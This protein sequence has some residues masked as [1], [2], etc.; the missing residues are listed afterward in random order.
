[1]TT[2]QQVFWDNYTFFAG[3]GDDK[4]FLD[5]IPFRNHISN[6]LNVGKSHRGRSYRMIHWVFT[7]NG[8]K[9]LDSIK[10]KHQ[11]RWDQHCTLFSFYC[12]LMHTG[13]FDL[14]KLKKAVSHVDYIDNLIQVYL[15]MAM[16]CDD[17]SFASKVYKFKEWKE[18]GKFLSTDKCSERARQNICILEGLK[19]EALELELCPPHDLF[20]ESDSDSSEEE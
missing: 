10:L 17:R 19:T 20:I 4:T 16:A 6:C 14:D 18:C 5:N 9:T 1:M 11:P 12:E 3:N 2:Q 7:P 15:A 13:S 8:L